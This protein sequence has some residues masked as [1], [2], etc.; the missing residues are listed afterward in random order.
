MLK[1]NLRN[2]KGF[3]LIELI[4]VI[5]IIAIIS[6]ILA[7]SFSR[8]TMRTRLKADISTA[9]ELTRQASLYNADQGQYPTNLSDLK[10]KEY[11]NEAPKPQ[12]EGA[13]FDWQGDKY[14]VNL[15]GADEKVKK[16]KE[17]LSEDEKAFTN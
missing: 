1:K 8:M 4:I 7:P 9:R 6:A 12:T 17:T 5:A 11:I 10:D 2:E 13:A 16:I 14:V 15:G 3:T